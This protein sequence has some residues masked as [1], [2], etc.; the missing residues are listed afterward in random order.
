[1]LGDLV[2]RV[3]E[4]MK[5]HQPSGY[6]LLV[7]VAVNG[8]PG[9]EEIVFEAKGVMFQG[10]LWYVVRHAPYACVQTSTIAPMHEW[11]TRVATE[12]ESLKFLLRETLRASFP[13]R[14]IVVA[15]PGSKDSVLSKEAGSG[16]ERILDEAIAALGVLDCPPSFL[17]NVA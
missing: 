4:Q 16:E 8:R 15:V 10:K 5:P 13:N 1:M 11:T 3:V 17:Q 12:K 2:D 14:K 7:C 9:V 6:R